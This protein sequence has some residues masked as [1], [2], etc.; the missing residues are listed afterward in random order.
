LAV[1]IAFIWLVTLSADVGSFAR[2]ARASRA[3]VRVHNFQNGET[4][5]YPVVLLR[6]DLD[7]RSAKSITVT[8]AS[9][10]RETRQ[11]DG[12]AR[13]GMFK[14]LT[15]LVP[16][17]NELVLK[18]GKLKASLTLIYRPQTNPY[19]VRAVYFTDK[20]GD[21]K[22]ETPLRNDPQN[23]RA[24]L[25]TGMKLMQCFTAASLNARGHGRKTFNLEFDK[26]GDVK[27]HLLKGTHSAAYYNKLTEEKLYHSVARELERKLPRARAKN[28]M[29]PAMARLDPNLGKTHV[30]VGIGGRNLALCRGGGLF[31]WPDRLQEGQ[32]AFMDA[33]P[34]DPNRVLTDSEQRLTHWAIC[35]TTMIVALHELGH[36]FGLRHTRFPRDIMSYDLEGLNRFFTLVEPPHAKRKDTLWLG[37][38]G[39][40]NW[41]PLSAAALCA[42]RHFALD[43]RKWREHPQPGVR[44]DNASGRIVIESEYGVR[45]IEVIVWDSGLF[46]VDHVPPGGGPSPPKRVEVALARVRKRAGSRAGVLRV[47]DGEGLAVSARLTDL[48]AGPFVRAWRVPPMTTPADEEGCWS[49]LDSRRLRAIEAAAPK[50]RL[51]RS[52][53]PQVHLLRLSNAETAKHVAA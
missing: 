8:N 52:G 30:D 37:W 2:A 41:S 34:V 43:A 31:T 1:S 7:D 15:E 50:A 21:T 17:E 13:F 9:S 51:V 18:T 10:R 48:L 23:W 53:S 46:A 39:V 33:R 44:F 27:V 12:P 5:R 19:I 20:T 24:K 38:A 49:K 6:G 47:I 32:K 3:P 4:V 11:M 29:I 42:S 16:G 25:A 28:L 35:S 40:A 45:H 14:V 36:T 26:A 22:Y